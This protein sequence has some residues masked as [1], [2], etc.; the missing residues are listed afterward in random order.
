MSTSKRSILRGLVA[1]AGGHGGAQ[2][3]GLVRFA[4]LARLLGTAEFGIAAAFG[5]TA[6]LLEMLSDVG[7]DRQIVQSPDGNRRPM[8]GTLHLLQLS[9]GIVLGVFMLLVAGPLARLSSAPES[10]WAFQL[11]ALAPLL[12]GLKHLDHARYQRRLKFAP[13]VNVSL[14]GQ[15][16]ALLI[17]VPVAW[18][19]RHH[20]AMLW[21]VL[22]QYAAMAVVSHLVARRRFTL[23]WNRQLAARALRFSWPLMGSGILLAAIFHGDRLVV[24]AAYPVEELAF[25]SV[26]LQLATVPSLVAAKVLAALSLPL[27]AS[28]A[29]DEIA[30]RRRYTQVIQ[31]VGGMCVL[32]AGTLLLVGPPVIYFV[33]GAEYGPAIPLLSVVALRQAIRLLRTAPNQAAMSAGDTLNMLLCNVVRALF[34]LPVAVVA[35]WQWPVIWIAGVGLVGEA[36][37][38]VTAAIALRWRLGKPLLLTLRPSL[39]VGLLLALCGLPMLLPINGLLMQ[40]VGA[41][42]CLIAMG[43]GLWLVNS[44]LNLQMMQRV[45]R[46]AGRNGMRPI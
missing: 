26:A 38:V 33:F 32:F 6:S 13:S 18:Y 9:R 28:V 35:V 34:V 12:S 1:L 8:Q 39:E 29:N 23:T 25:Y 20:T 3:I 2:A 46:L 44:R 27:L 45:G 36:A 37:A 10:T 19:T 24:L 14:A 7:A 16:V 4:V 11:L 42:T 43:I 31:G 22:A 21:A 15:V 41:S 40:I 30:F 17:A 5:L